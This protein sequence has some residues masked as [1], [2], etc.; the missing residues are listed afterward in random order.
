MD[1][2]ILNHFF[3]CCGDY[4]SAQAVI[5]GAPMD[6]TVSFR[7]GSRFGP[8]VI[9]EMSWVLESYSPYVGRDMEEVAIYDFG[10]LELAFGNAQ[11]SLNIIY[12]AARKILE[13]GKLPLFIGGEHLISLPVIKAVYEKY[14]DDLIL[15]HFDAHTDLRE[16]YLGEGLSH[17]T[18]I[19]QCASFIKPENIYQFGIRSGL[20]EEFRWGRENTNFFPFEVLAPLR[21]SIE[22]VKE[23][24]VYVTLD[25]DVVDPAYAPGTGTPEA[26]GCTSAEILQAVHMLKGCNIVGF[27]LVEV[28]TFGDP[29][30]ITAVLA[31]KIIRE[32]LLTFL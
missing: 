27:D 11:K 6:F 1:R 17:A 28:M 8:S 32:A 5:V 18:V 22:K 7:P 21:K 31:A 14:G 4:S 26:G 10:D 23:R 20:E 24:P 15:L 9:R 16:E 12:D 2:G 3:G 13:D 30:K 29:G 25:I 19:R